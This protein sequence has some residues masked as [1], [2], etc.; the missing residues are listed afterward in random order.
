VRT[1]GGGPNQG[2]NSVSCATLTGKGLPGLLKDF[3]VDPAPPP[4]TFALGPTHV[5]AFG[6]GEL[7]AEPRAGGMPVVL[8]PS[9]PAPLRVLADENAAFVLD[10]AGGIAAYPFGGGGPLPRS[11]VAGTFHDMAFGAHG[12]VFAVETAGGDLEIYAVGRDGS[13]EAPL[14]NLGPNPGFQALAARG[15][16]VFVAVDDG[17]GGSSVHRVPACF[18]GPAQPLAAFANAPVRAMC[19]DDQNLYLLEEDPMEGVRLR[20][21]SRGGGEATVLARPGPG[22]AYGDDEIA[23]VKGFVYLLTDDGRDFYRVKRR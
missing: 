13:G 19:T 12:I 8:D 17:A 18:P 3:A 4:H 22:F 20:Q 1:Q 23:A 2:K 5:A 6:N 15:P 21:V 11:T 16:D 10:A 14:A 7:H 9:L